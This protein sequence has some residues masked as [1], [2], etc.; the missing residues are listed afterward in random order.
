MAMYMHIYDISKKKEKPVLKIAH[1][2]VQLASFREL[3]STL[4]LSLLQHP[5]SCLVDGALLCL[6]YFGEGM[7]LIFICRVLLFLKAL[8]KPRI[9]SSTQD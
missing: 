6:P 8:K 9:S 3:F 7:Y 5:P 1:F 4:S 2:L